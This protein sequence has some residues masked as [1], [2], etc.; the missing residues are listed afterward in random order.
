M[1]NVTEK[2]LNTLTEK[3]KTDRV[4]IKI[5]LKDKDKTVINLTDEDIIKG[6]I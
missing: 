3:T 2:Y 5:T 1:Y 4:E 6:R